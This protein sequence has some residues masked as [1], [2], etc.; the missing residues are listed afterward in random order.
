MNLYDNKLRARVIEVHGHQAT[1]GI[2]VDGFWHRVTARTEVPLNPGDRI[3][4]RLTITSEEVV[5][6][7]LER[8]STESQPAPSH[9]A[10]PIGIDLEV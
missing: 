9:T 10:P 5:L 6:F 7:R 1:L 4:G 3:V 2:Y 8:E